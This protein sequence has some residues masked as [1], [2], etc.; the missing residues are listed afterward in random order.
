MKILIDDFIQ[1]F[2]SFVKDDPM[3]AIGELMAWVSLPILL[4]MLSVIGG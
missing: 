1:E 2:V 3:E 4:F